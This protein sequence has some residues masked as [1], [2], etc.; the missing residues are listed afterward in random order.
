VLW[1]L[2]RLLLLGWPLHSILQPLLVFQGLLR[3]RVALGTCSAC[4][5]S[6]LLLLLLTRCA[7]LLTLQP[8]LL[9]CCRLLRLLLLLPRAGACWGRC[10][11]SGRALLC[12][13]GTLVLI[14]VQN[15]DWFTVCRLL[16]G[17]LILIKRQ[18]DSVD[19]MCWGPGSQ[20]RRRPGAMLPALLRCCTAPTDMPDACSGQKHPSKAELSS[21]HK[22]GTLLQLLYCCCGCSAQEHAADV[23]MPC[24][25]VGSV[26]YAEQTRQMLHRW[27]YRMQQQMIALKS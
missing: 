23:C 3:W 14:T 13:A 12:C 11:C 17:I 6:R 7:L 26:T 19:H 18:I 25:G 4:R 1:R 21:W 22:S 9:C 27:I 8:L 15:L 10:C 16:W 5:K 20:Q 24:K 2:L